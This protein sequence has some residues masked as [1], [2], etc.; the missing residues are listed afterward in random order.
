MKMN[1]KRTISLVVI[2]AAIAL[3]AA[4]AWFG[5]LA[6]RSGGNPAAAGSS[7]EDVT[8]PRI[9][10]VGVDQARIGTVASLLRL[11]GEIV[12]TTT[13]DA[14][15]EVAG[16]LQRLF[17]QVGDRVARGRTIASVDPSRPGA[18]FEAAPVTAPISGTITA[19]HV[20]VGGAVATTKPIVTV[21]VLDALEV[22]VDV[23]ER[24]VGVVQP[25]MTAEIALWAFPGAPFT[26]TAGQIS[27]LL[28]ATTR[29][30]EVRFPIDP[31][32][33]RAEAGMFVSVTIR[34]EVRKDVVLVPIESVIT[35]YGES[36]VYTV[37]D[38]STAAIVPVEVGLIGTR[39]TE[40]RSGL[41]PGDPIVVRGQHAIE[42]G[43]HLQVIATDAGGDR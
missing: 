24:F 33:S 40:I 30:K 14:L 23:P 8:A 22:V 20:A 37:G 27:P 41:D 18:R 11:D 17:V 34:N 25:G 38:D 43:S 32:G 1:G 5:L 6:P 21:G 35:R 4:A 29:T 28:N 26:A 13:V 16:K 3:V 31:A 39:S 12:P 10:T 15:P 36:F 42:S 9:Y 2:A 7:N 19:V